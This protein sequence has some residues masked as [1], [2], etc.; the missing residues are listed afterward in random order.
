GARSVIEFPLQN[1]HCLLI[2]FIVDDATVQ[3]ESRQRYLHPHLME[4]FSIDHILHSSIVLLILS[5]LFISLVLR[6]LHFLLLRI[7]I[8]LGY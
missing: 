7:S 8:P 1:L 6:L 2:H 3:L 5:F 4:H